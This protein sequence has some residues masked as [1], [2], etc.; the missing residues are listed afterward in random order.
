MNSRF[1]VTKSIS[2]GFIY[3]HNQFERFHRE[4]GPAKHKEDNS[5]YAWFFDG[6]RHRTNGAALKD[7]LG[8]LTWYYKDQMHRIGGP[9]FQGGFS[10]SK[11]AAWWKNNSRHRLNAPAIV[12]K[13]GSGYRHEYYEFGVHIKYSKF[14]A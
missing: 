3:Y 6:K 1:V 7:Y 11:L 2:N 8:N 13:A 4:D 14:N 10:N 12:Y 9:S 5:E